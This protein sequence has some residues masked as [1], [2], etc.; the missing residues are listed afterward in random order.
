MTSNIG[1]AVPRIVHRPFEGRMKHCP[2]PVAPGL[3]SVARSRPPI[4]TVGCQRVT[5]CVTALT[6]NPG[7]LC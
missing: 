2:A 5:S 6:V 4:A 7:D 3:H 1:L